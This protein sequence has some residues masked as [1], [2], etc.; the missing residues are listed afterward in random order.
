MLK[1]HLLQH[2]P[3]EGPGAIQPWLEKRSLFLST[4]RLYMGESLPDPADVELLVVMGAPMSVNDESEHRWLAPEKRFIGEAIG[5]GARVLGIC[6]GAQ[7]VAAALGA[8]V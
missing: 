4:I 1:A 2:V 7:L 6:L 8:R 5:R 3:F